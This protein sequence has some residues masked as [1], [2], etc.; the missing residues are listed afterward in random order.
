MQILLFNLA[1]FAGACAQGMTGFGSGTLTV[2]LLV[3]LFPFR[4]VIATVAMVVLVPNLM[5]TWL[6]RHEMDWRRGPVAALGLSLGIVVGGQLLAIL[7]AELL[8]RGLGMAIL[9]YVGLMLWRTPTPE[10]APPRSPREAGFLFGCGAVSGVIVGAVGVSPIPLLIY[11][12]LRYP[13]Q[14]ARSVLTLAFFCGTI[15]Q[16]IVYFQ[17]GLLTGELAL[18]ALLT[19][20]GIALGLLVGNRLHYKINQKTFARALALILLLP[21]LRLV[22]G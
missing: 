1:A 8:R 16:N 20:P 7:P 18:M 6:T 14:I 13:K 3:M 2:S 17:L 9:V 21:A 22:W 19:V 12:S 11:V 5:L 4:D 10:H 15:T